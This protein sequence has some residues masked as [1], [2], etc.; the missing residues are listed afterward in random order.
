M[1]FSQKALVV[2][3]AAVQAWCQLPTSPVV[4]PRGVINAVSNRPA[5][6]VAAPG[7]I[8]RIEGF[9]LGPPEGARAPGLPLPTALGDPPIRVLI[10]GKAAPI[11]AA[12]P[13][14]IL[15]Q[16]PWDTEPGPAVV[17]VRRGEAASRPARVLINRLAPAVRTEN[18]RG[19]GEIAGTLSGNVLLARATG[20]GPTE[21][22]VGDGVPGPPDP[23]ARPRDAVRAFVGG[24]PAPVRATLSPERPGEFDLRIELP[25]GTRPGDVLTVQAGAVTAA[26]VTVGKAAGPEIQWLAAADA[27]PF[28]SFVSPGMTA[29]YAIAGAARN[30]QGCYPSYLFDFHR[31]RAGRIDACLTAAPNARTPVVPSTDSPRLAALLGPPAGDASSGIS[32]KVIVF[33]ATREEPVTAELPEPAVG[34]TA[35]AGGNFAAVLAGTPPRALLVDGRTGEVREAP[36]AAGGVAAALGPAPKSDDLPHAL[37]V[38]GLPDRYVAALLA[39]DPD[40]PTRA[41][42]VVTDREGQP[43]G[44]RDFPEGWVPLLAPGRPQTGR[45]GETAQARR[46]LVYLDDIKQ[47]L[48]VLSRHTD[49]SRQAMV[50]FSLDDRE[51]VVAPFPDGWF[52]ASCTPNLPVF[53]LELARKIVV[54]GAGAPESEIKDPCPATGFVLVDLETRQIQ[55][56]ALPGQ[57]QFDAGAAGGDVN[58]FIFAVNVDSSRRNVADT[59]FVLDGV[60]SSVLRMDLPPRVRGFT[61]LTP[62]PALNAVVALA[63]ERAAGDAGFVYFDLE[64]AETKLLPAPDGFAQVSLV[65]IFEATRKLVARGIHSGGTG[66]QYLIYDLNTGDLLLPSFP[67]AAAWVGNV[68]RVVGQT[69]G[70][71]P[72]QPGQGQSPPGQPAQPGQGQPAPGQ[73]T[74]PGQG[75][76][77]Q[78]APGATPAQPAAAPILQQSSPRSNAVC[79][80]AYDR[81]GRQS[82]ALLLRI[83]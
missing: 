71:A 15:V 36:A 4:N 83:P 2:V 50:V 59:L 68:V 3:A 30:A 37:A 72:A 11:F 35:L 9:N 52:A 54:P 39:D 74:Q 42:L 5:P 33:D 44:S 1:R 58:D 10:N 20:L 79:A 41:R 24:L 76:T 66:S 13:D 48:Y 22:A 65:G 61:G 12:H 34:L 23:P 17:V 45:A 8:L 78:P 26:P 60:T 56:V 64:N 32:A 6:S 55:A 53:N 40:R 46:V 51:P 21:P 62:L 38:V 28:Q 31:K 75:G 70:Q 81:E 18:D 67:E 49:D 43:Q 14:R 7:A 69:A 77:T 16:V 63:V 47:V 25:A 82:G 27:P 29:S 57:S 19:F 73:P 80:V